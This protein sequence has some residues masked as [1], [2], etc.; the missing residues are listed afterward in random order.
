MLAHR[1]THIDTGQLLIKRHVI[2]RW[3][4]TREWRSESIPSKRQVAGSDD[5]PQSGR[6]SDSCPYA[7]G[8]VVGT[9]REH[10]R[11][12][13]IPTHRIHHGTV[14]L[15]H[16]D[17]PFIPA[18]PDIHTTICKEHMRVRVGYDTFGSGRDELIVMPAETREDHIIPV[19]RPDQCA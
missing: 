16:G 8:A 17:R 12:D 11:I 18:I 14:S 5:D 2:S 6:G 10:R 7:H 9:G 13:G 15:E 4:D 1:L 19:F 3:M